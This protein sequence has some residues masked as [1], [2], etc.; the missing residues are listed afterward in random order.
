MNCQTL[1][2]RLEKKSWTWKISDLKPSWLTSLELKDNPHKQ[3]CT[4]RVMLSPAQCFIWQ[5]SHAS[6]P[7][8]PSGTG[9]A[10][11]ARNELCSLRR[12]LLSAKRLHSVAWTQVKSCAAADLI[13]R[14]N[15]EAGCQR[16]R[17]YLKCTYLTYLWHFCCSA[18]EGNKEL[19]PLLRGAPS[20]TPYQ[21]GHSPLTPNATWGAL[22]R[23]LMH[24][25]FQAWHHLLLLLT[26]LNYF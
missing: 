12:L 6:R 14:Q 24:D 11:L 19:L 8:H 15:K 22:P 7:E 18:V 5:L 13:K 1:H 9:G 2:P 20:F 16:H 10:D 17:S 21:G 23:V 3:R 26:Y 4:S 25:V